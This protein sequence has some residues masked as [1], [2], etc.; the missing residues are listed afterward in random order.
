MA[1]E[2][3]YVIAASKTVVA[4]TTILSAGTALKGW[5]KSDPLLTAASHIAPIPSVKSCRTSAVLARRRLAAPCNSSYAGR[6][7]GMML[8]RLKKLF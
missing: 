3:G 8:S 6:C 1:V 2:Y 7:P 4:F 5:R